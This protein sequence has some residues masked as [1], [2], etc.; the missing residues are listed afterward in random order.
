MSANH[1]IIGLGGTGGKIIRAYRKTIFQEFR[2]EEP[3]GASVGY[4]Y[5]DSSSEMMAIDDPSWKILG[6]SVQLD[7]KSQLLIQDASLSTRLENIN[8][9]PGI[10]PWIGSVDQWRDVLGSIIG[11]ALG[12]QKRRLGRFLFAC[13]CPLFREQVQ[14][15]VRQLQSSGTTDTTF[16]ICCGLAGGT[17]SGSVIDAISQVRD[18]Y[19]DS[20]RYR[21]I[22]YALLPETHPNP[23][24]DTGNYHAN[25]YGA[26]L[27]A[28]AISVGRYDP[29]DLTGLKGRLKLNDPFNGCYLFTNENENGLTVDVDKELPAIIADFLYEKTIAVR[30][31]AWPTLGRI[32]NAENG[33][34]SP[35]KAPASNIPERSKRFLTFGI[36]RLAIPEEEIAEYL[37]FNFARQAALQLRFNNWS[38]TNGFSD[39][40]RNQDYREFVRQKETEYK[41]GL[42]D[43]HL[44]LSIGILSDDANNKKWKPINNDWQDVTPQIKSTVHEEESARW[45]DE[46]AKLFVKRFDQDYRGLGVRNFY[47]AKLNAKKEHVIEIRRRVEG[48]L[49]TDWKNGVRSLHDL[50]SLLAA[51]LESTDERLKAIDEKIPQAEDNEEQAAERV[52][53]HNRAWSSMGW[54]SRVVLRKRDRLLDAQADTFLEQYIYRTR[55]EALTFAK[56]LMAEIVVGLTDLKGQIDQCTSTVNEA[57]KQYSDRIAERITDD[58]S[59]DLRAQLVRFYKPELVRTITKNLVKDESEQRTQTNRVRQAILQKLGESPNFTLFNER[60]SLADFIDLLDKECANNARIAHNNLVQDRKEKLFG[61][62]IIERLKERYGGDSQELRT[63]ITELVARAGNYLTFDQ[64]EKSKSGPGIPMGAQTA[65]SMMSVIMPKA[66]EESDFVAKLK[67]V[68]QGARPTQVEI[69]DG[70]TRPNEI[71]IISLTNLFPLRYASQVG[72]LKQKFDS[73]VNGPDGS[74][75]KLELL[76]EGDGTQFPN[77]FVPAQDEVIKDALPYVLLA[78]SLKLIQGGRNPKTGSAELLVVAKDENGFDTEP[79][80]LGKTLG[81]CVNNLDLADADRLKSYVKK[82]LGNGQNLLDSTRSQLQEA[83]VAAVDAIKVECGNNVQDQL[84]RRFLEGG[85]QAVSMLKV[86]S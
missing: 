46:L 62:S 61:V 76:S 41:W 34:G 12:G 14:A 27:E 85:K 74:R 29:V 51:L 48:D 15:L 33:D 65:V 77:L 66:P 72:F 10:K 47:R 58:G 35:E 63:Y 82:L 69:I 25:G 38:G 53:A 28:N 75:A 57:I 78:N 17:G 20:R 23:S 18:L 59:A 11:V 13:K 26:L 39:E 36:K 54:F 64:S 5:V 21:V 16:H 44:T 40:A 81:D 56:Q 7:R 45:L 2:K 42:S 71:V 79:I 19:P 43:E 83:V 24:W 68:F 30:D 50:S 49:F 3:D 67:A 52:K 84:Y 9:Y 70:D 60:I 8:N 4:L 73:K 31:I 6:T 32:E 55:I 22:V 86:G 37:T 80:Y 1:L